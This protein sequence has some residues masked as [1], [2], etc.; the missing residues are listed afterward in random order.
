MA[1]AAPVRL[2]HLSCL[3]CGGQ[4]FDPDLMATTVAGIN[5]C[6]PDLV[7][8]AGNLTDHGY[9]WE[10][11]EARRY[12][13][14]IE[15][16]LVVVPG[17]DDSRN[18]GYVHYQRH[19]GERHT[20][21]RLELEGSRAE[22]LETSGITVLALDSSEPDLAAGRIGREWYPWLRERLDVPDDLTVVMLHH[23]LVA[24]PG[25]GRESTV[26]EDAG[27]LLALLSELE[28]D[29]ILTGSRHVPFFWGLNGMLI[30]NSGAAGSRASRGTVP[31]SWNELEID[32]EK[33][34]IYVRYEDGSRQLAAVRSRSMRLVARAGFTMTDDFFT[35]NALPV[36]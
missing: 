7:L 32:E 2:A 22:T 6:Q 1:D 13:A 8:V 31:P 10:Y 20:A 28:V 21:H 3:H 30:C 18:V 11:D 24:I 23:H 27:D 19:F 15:A 25:A 14:E 26:V 4:H 35:S 33:V 16:P 29:V 12:L 34:Q 9:E 36:G 17:S 5:R